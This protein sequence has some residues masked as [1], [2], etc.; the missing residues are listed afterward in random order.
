[1]DTDAFPIDSPMNDDSSSHDRLHEQ[2]AGN[3]SFDFYS[4]LS[5]SSMMDNLN[6]VG[7]VHVEGL[8][9]RR[10]GGPDVTSSPEAVLLLSALFCAVGTVGFV[11]NIL[12]V[13]VIGEYSF[14]VTAHFVIHVD[15]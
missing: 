2:Q 5:H 6:G 8:E 9:E 14:T 13:V 1:M 15:S 10:G 12:I 3:V 7:G 4:N 11:G